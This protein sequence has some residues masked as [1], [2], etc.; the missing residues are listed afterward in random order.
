[1]S[2]STLLVLAMAAIAVV[3]NTHAFAPN[4]ISSLRTRQQQQP[5]SAF[6]SALFA[7]SPSVAIP[8]P[9]KK[10]PW[11][12]QKEREREAR[13][14][15]LERAKL[16]RE[17]GIVED[18]TYEEIVEATERLIQLAGSDLKRKIKI[19]VAKDK[20]LQIR[21]N[22]RLAG[23]AAQSKE[24]RAQSTYEIEGN[25]EDEIP[26]A[27]KEWNAP[28][29]TRNLVV[30]PDGK[31]V[32]SQARLWGIISLIGLAFPPAQ[33]YLGRFTWLV[34]VAQLTFRGMPLEEREAGGMGI[35][36][37]AGGRGGSGGHRKVAFALGFSIWVMGSVLV[38]SLMPTW[39][40]GQRWTDSLAFV[41][42]NVLYAL[43]SCYLQPY[44]G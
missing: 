38:Y 3:T 15:K 8:N 22:E 23:L 2:A 42:Q 41:L 10:L 32:K 14:L 36:F 12:V 11:N 31:Q 24:A 5:S 39:A 13:R 17:L 21:L 19:E 37:N 30:K 26:K 7:K 28:L 18:A 9:F 44:K 33:E 40:R 20:I 34:C 25:D 4:S 29:W 43:A 35:N 27:A 1:M 6:S 16:H